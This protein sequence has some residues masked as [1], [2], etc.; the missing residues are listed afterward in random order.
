MNSLACWFNRAHVWFVPCSLKKWGDSTFQCGA[1]TNI[2]VAGGKK[3]GINSKQ[4]SGRISA[5]LND[6]Q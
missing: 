5:A 2:W 1:A 3:W 4:H 6:I